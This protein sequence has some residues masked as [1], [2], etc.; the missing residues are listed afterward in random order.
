MIRNLLSV[1]F[2][3]FVGIAL[4]AQP[5]TP[6]SPAGCVL[7]AITYFSLKGEGG[8]VIYS[9]SGCSSGAYADYTATYSPVNLTFGIAYSGFLQTNS[10]DNYVSIW[11]DHDNDDQFEA[12][13]RVMHNMKIGPTPVLY[14]I[15]IPS[16][17]AT[18]THRMRVRN[19]YYATEPA[20]ATLTDPCALINFSET[21]D[22]LVN[23]TN[24]PGPKFVSSGIPGACMPTSKICIGSATNNESS[25]NI[26]LLDSNNNYVAGIYPSGNTLGIV[27]GNLV[28]NN[29]SVRQSPAPSNSYYMDRNVTI[30]TTIAPLSNYNLRYFYLNSELNALIA[31][32]GSGVTSQFDLAMTKNNQANCPADVNNA[33]PGTLYF[34]T[35]FGSMSGDRFVDMTGLSGFSTFYLHGGSQPIGNGSVLL[36][37]LISFEAFPKN[38]QV[39]LNW[40]IAQSDENIR[41]TLERSYDGQNFQPI[42]ELTGRDHLQNEPLY[43]GFTDA[44]PGTGNIYYRL[45]QTDLEMKVAFSQVR[46]VSISDRLAS[47]SMNQAGDQLSIHCNADL[48]AQIMEISGKLIRH[49]DLKSGIHIIDISSLPSG[50]YLFVS[51]HQVDKFVR[52]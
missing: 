14:G 24:S 50:M 10:S 36:V 18:G 6:S 31:Q 39:E 1:L 28:R 19:A 35:G 17:F 38:N 7:D 37:D 22:Y 42:A 51:K 33:P 21:E 49:V 41:F 26:Q 43:F 34:S 5:C 2:L 16:S 27:S 8:T 20:Y 13:E 9:P 47:Y 25:P 3:Q 4:S 11:I 29:G 52:W 12:N 32:P 23:I 44:Q 46:K 40:Q 15:F 48:S 30:S 45:K